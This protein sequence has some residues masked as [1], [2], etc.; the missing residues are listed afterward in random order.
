MF[1]QPWH[2]Q[3]FGLKHIFLASN[4]SAIIN[5][6]YV[7]QIS[8]NTN[9]ISSYLS[10]SS[11]FFL[12]FSPLTVTHISRLELWGR[13]LGRGRNIQWGGGGEFTRLQR[14][15]A[16]VRFG[17]HRAFAAH[18][19]HVVSARDTT[20]RCGSSAAGQGGGGECVC[21]DNYELLL[22]LLNECVAR[23]G[24]GRGGQTMHKHAKK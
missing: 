2:S 9:D 5:Q 6:T 12:S 17:S 4:R 18:A 15:F 21:L 23:G 1:V 11:F 24:R 19:S 10:F 14:Q 7:K 3:K 20:F 22:I 16:A 8:T 13:H